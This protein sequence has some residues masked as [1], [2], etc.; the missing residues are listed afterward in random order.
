[1][2]K[3]K[4]I[5]KNSRIEGRLKKFTNDNFLIIL[6]AKETSIRL[7]IKHYHEKFYHGSH[8]TVLNELRQ[9]FWI[10]GLRHGLRSLVA[11]CII[12]KVRKGQPTNPRMAEL[13]LARIAYRLK[14]FSHCGL[15]YFGPMMVKIGRRREKRWG[16]IFTYMTTRAVHIEL[17][18]SLTTDSAIMAL[19]KFMARYTFIH[20]LR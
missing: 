6:D 9:K 4:P 16:A 3:L 5:P 13:L 1:M 18:H 2:E 12:C 11:K 20:L 10:V 7:L 15:D 8:E 14:P 17:A 19:K